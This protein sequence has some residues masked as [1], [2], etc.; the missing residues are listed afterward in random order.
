MMSSL[1]GDGRAASTF[2]ETYSFSTPFPFFHDSSRSKIW[3]KGF[4]SATKVL[5]NSMGG[6]VSTLSVRNNFKAVALKFSRPWLVCFAYSQNM[7]VPF[8]SA[9]SSTR[10]SS[11]S[12]NFQIKNAP[13]GV[14]ENLWRWAESNR[15]AHDCSDWIYIV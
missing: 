1:C 9:R 12:T 6:T 3:E 2:I 13:K 14:F 7:T 15:R 11:I 8:D 4:D 5:L 10:A